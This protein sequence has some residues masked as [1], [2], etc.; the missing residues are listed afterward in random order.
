M[1]AAVLFEIDQPLQ[2]VEVA[3]PLPGIGQVAVRIEYSGL[4]RSQLMEIQGGRNNQKYIPHMLGHEGVGSVISIGEGVTKVVPGDRVVLGWI[5]GLGLDVGGANYKCG[6][7]VVNSGAVTTLS[8]QTIVSE[9][10]LVK[11]PEGIPPKV[12]VLFGCALPT[13][14]GIVFNQIKPLPGKNIAIFGLGGVGMSALIAAQCFSPARLFAVDVCAEKLALAKELGATDTIDA[15]VQ[16]PVQLL[17]DQTNGGVDYS[18]E[19]AGST[20]TIEQAFSAVRDGGGECVFAS[21]PPDTEMIRL[22]P[23]AFHRGKKISGSWGGSANPDVDIPK[24][25]ELFR[26]GQLPLERLIS[27]TYSLDKVNEAVDDLDEGKLVRAIIDTKPDLGI[28]DEF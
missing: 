9:N 28:S 14:A 17:L 4:C 22:E 15:S 8:E 3:M 10:R 11:L 21:H 5:K 2:L 19:S 24:L 6:D 13:G 25:A 20:K 26:K 18:I 12:A 16:D 1:K 7:I 27:K 23:H